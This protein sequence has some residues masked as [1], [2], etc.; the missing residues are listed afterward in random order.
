[1]K[2]KLLLE[3]EFFAER[4]LTYSY[5]ALTGVLNRETILEYGRNLQEQN[6]PFAMLICDLDNF[7]YVNDNYGHKVGDK[8]L[9]NVAEGLMKVAEDKAVV[10]RFGGDEF[11]IIVPNT[12]EYDDLWKFCQKVNFSVNAL[13]IDELRG[14]GLTMTVG[15][16]RY[17]LDEQDCEKLFTTADKALYRGKQKGRN[18]FIIYLPEKHA[19]IKIGEE[20]KAMFS[21][22][23]MNSKIYG[24]MTHS[25]NVKENIDGVLRYLSSTLMIDHLCIQS[26][27]KICETVVYPLSPVQMFSYIPYE[28]LNSRVNSSGICVM[29]Q[30]SMIKG[31]ETTSFYRCFEKQ[32]V[33]GCVL[34]RIEAFDQVYGFLRAESASAV[35][36]IW[37]NTEIDYLVVFAKLLG[38]ILYFTK[39]DLDELF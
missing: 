19:N 11:I 6:T 4:D 7:K 22:M 9:I 29:N 26:T 39:S 8:I 16:S 28:E 25:L 1:M 12:V 21:S 33:G 30:L 3:D 35:G 20:G 15:A 24:I 5:D 37:Q 2:A 32:G 14:A 31:L 38:V 23:D 10:G 36:R 13:N 34:V 18:C 27:Q 17:P